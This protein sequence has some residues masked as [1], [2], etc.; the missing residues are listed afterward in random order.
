[1]TGNKSSHEGRVEYRVVFT[2]YLCPMNLTSRLLS[3]TVPS[4]RTLGTCV[5]HKTLK[6]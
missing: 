3:A 4:G 6:C 2:R 1:M 5:L